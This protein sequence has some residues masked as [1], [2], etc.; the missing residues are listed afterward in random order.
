MSHWELTVW[1]DK[2]TGPTAPSSTQ[3]RNLILTPLFP[4]TAYPDI[5]FDT[6]TEVLVLVLCQH[7]CTATI[8]KPGKTHSKCHWGRANLGKSCMGVYALPTAVVCPGGTA[9]AQTM[10]SSS[11][12]VSNSIYLYDFAHTVPTGEWTTA[13]RTWSLPHCWVHAV[14]HPYYITKMSGNVKSYRKITCNNNACLPHLTSLCGSCCQDVPRDI[15]SKYIGHLRHIELCTA[16][17]HKIC[18]GQY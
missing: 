4:Q 8:T 6:Y 13:I 16:K 7:R 9:C 17:S 3:L 2:C 18:C 14:K 15:E 11:I 12:T 5:E 10:P 1:L